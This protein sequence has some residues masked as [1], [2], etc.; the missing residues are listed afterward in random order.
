MST[1]RWNDDIAYVFFIDRIFLRIHG[2]WPLQTQTLFTRI[3]WGFCL[4][5]LIMI[6][7]YLMLDLTSSN[8]NANINLEAILLV[9]SV[10]L[11]IMKHLCIGLSQKKLN[12]NINGA[13]DDWLSVKDDKETR[14]IMKEY[15]YKARV[16]TLMLLYSIAG[17]FSAYVLVVLFK[18]L[19]QIFFTDSNLLDANTTNWI[20]LFPC[21]PLSKSI[22]GS[23]YV[24]ILAIQ[25]VQAVIGC[26]VLFIKSSFFFNV[27]MHLAGQVE[28]LKNKF[29]TFANKPNTEA[30]YRKK[31]IGLI[32]RHSKLMEF[33][34]NLEDS[35]NF[36]ILIE[37]VIVTIMLAF[38]GLRIIW[39]LM[40]NNYI[41]VAK[42]ALDVIIYLIQLMIYTYA[43]DL[44]QRESEGIFYAIYATSWFTL[45]LTLMKDMH[46][47]MMKSSIPFRFTGGKFF[48]VNRA[49]MM[50]IFKA[51]YSYISVLRV[52]LLT[53]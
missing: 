17:C 51:T 14:K 3:R 31:F 49:T 46:F 11:A 8:Q 48:Y 15:A 26:S 42:N 30:N 47:A 16:L 28:V 13:I 29:Q 5:A 18:N 44:L 20:L 35:F 21:D 22:T 23:Q 9:V 27:T 36:F 4:M 12:I 33:Y 7:P 50:F 39:C 10:M 6:I 38:I 34:Q 52:A 25:L 41:E 53:K 45:P 32:N 40:E 19:K 24:I 2:V 1:E 43:G 37:L